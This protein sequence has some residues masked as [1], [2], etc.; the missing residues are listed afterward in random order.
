MATIHTNSQIIKHKLMDKI[1]GTTLLTAERDSSDLST[2]QL[3]EILLKRLGQDIDTPDLRDTPK[4]YVKFLTRFLTREEFTPTMFQGNGSVKCFE[5]MIIQ[6]NILFYSLCAHHILPFFG[7]VSVGYVPSPETA[8]IIGLSKISRLVREIS[9]NLTTQER[10]TAEVC[11]RLI[12][13]TKG[14]GAICQVK[15]RHMCMEMRGIEQFNAETVTYHKEGDIDKS[16]FFDL[17]KSK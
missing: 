6:T 11:K 5:N 7:T 12:N 14:A 2:E 3:V 15:A 4:R 8:Q 1:N 16:L 13:L 9:H 17:L 10:I